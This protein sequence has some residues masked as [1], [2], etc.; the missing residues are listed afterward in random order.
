M[1][2]SFEIRTFFWRVVAGTNSFLRWKK[3]TKFSFFI[4][5][6][7][8]R[9]EKIRLL[10]KFECGRS[11]ESVDFFLIKLVPFEISIHRRIDLSVS[12]LF[13]SVLTLLFNTF[14]MM[15][16]LFLL[17]SKLRE[18]EKNCSQKKHVDRTY[19]FRRMFVFSS[20]PLSFSLSLY[21]FLLFVS[22]SKSW[23]FVS[24]MLNDFVVSVYDDNQFSTLELNRQKVYMDSHHYHHLSPSLS[25]SLNFND[26]FVLR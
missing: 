13:L 14:A 2:I 17:T 10:N 18:R 4:R 23:S 6:I 26:R 24:P 22:E 20:F 8:R 19:F 3:N 12:F 21:M 16:I 15:F 7:W 11:N 5:H 9:G 1:E 25:L